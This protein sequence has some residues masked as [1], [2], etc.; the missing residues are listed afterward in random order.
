MYKCNKF[1]RHMIRL[2]PPYN[3]KLMMLR[4]TARKDAVIEKKK[5]NL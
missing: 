4:E 2:K 1:L 5:N 3:D